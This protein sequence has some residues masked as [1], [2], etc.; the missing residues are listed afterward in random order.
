MSSREHYHRPSHHSSHHR[1]RSSSRHRHSHY[2]SRHS[3][4]SPHSRFSRKDNTSSHYNTSN[5]Q[6]NQYENDQQKWGTVRTVK[7]VRKTKQITNDE[8]ILEFYDDE[9]KDQQHEAVELKRFLIKR[10]R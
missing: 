6:H 10:R 1:S 5:N 4:R 3:S 9:L 8:N 7:M 2:K